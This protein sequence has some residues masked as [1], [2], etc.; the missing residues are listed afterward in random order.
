MA[1]IWDATTR[2]DLLRRIDKLTPDGQPQWGK[3][4]TAQMVGHIAEPLR[5][6]IGELKVVLKI[7]FLRNPIMKYL[8]IHVLPFPKNAPTAPEFV[9]AGEDD[10][11]RNRADFRAVLDRFLAFREKNQFPEHV[12]FGKLSDK[13]W[14]IIMW[15]H[16]DHHLRQ[17]GV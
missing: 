16:I 11:V 4:N 10:L 9:H 6:A 1:T 17:F 15:K 3:M 14:G 5:Q 7:S 13:D 12:V 8:A 2:Q